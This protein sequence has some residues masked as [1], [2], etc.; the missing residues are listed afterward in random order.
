MSSNIDVSKFEYSGAYNRAEFEAEFVKQFS[1][2]PR[3]NSGAIPDLFRLLDLIENDRDMTDIRWTA[4]L[5]ATIMWETTSPHS[6]EKPALNKKGKPL[7]DKNGKPVMVKSWPWL[8]SMSPVDE[9]G[10]GKGRQYHEPVKVKLLDDGDVRITEHDGDQ[11]KVKLGGSISNLTKGAKLG[12][13]DGIP[14]S[15]VYE[16][17]DGTEHVYFGRGYVQLTWWSNYA[18][19]GIEIGLGYGLLLDPE[20][21]KQPATAYKIMSYGMRTGKIFANGHSFK[22]YFTQTKTNYEGARAMVNGSDHAADIAKIARQFEAVLLKAKV[23]TPT[24]AKAK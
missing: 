6:I 13:K 8:I 9:V 22:K 1:K 19:A 20:Q 4:Y 2:S 7:Y 11:F 18:K 10:H 15:S 17:D 21:V 23:I 24:Q 3:Y 5:L 14:A 12:A 16:K